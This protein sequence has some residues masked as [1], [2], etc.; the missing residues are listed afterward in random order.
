MN[1]NI[2]T[3]PETKTYF[4]LKIFVAIMVIPTIASGFLL[5]FAILEGTINR[6]DQFLSD[7]E[8]WVQSLVITSW[9][10]LYYF[11]KLNWE[12]RKRKNNKEQ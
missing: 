1:K 10:F 7:K 3:S 4:V 6:I 9:I 12:T 8:W 11:V 2:E 5:G